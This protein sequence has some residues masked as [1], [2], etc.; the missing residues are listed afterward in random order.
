MTDVVSDT[1]QA[2]P[3]FHHMMVL[4]AKFWFYNVKKELMAFFSI[5][6]T[7]LYSPCAAFPLAPVACPTG[8]SVAVNS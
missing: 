3:C 1:L 4:L 8:C 2:A 6:P 7:L 5:S